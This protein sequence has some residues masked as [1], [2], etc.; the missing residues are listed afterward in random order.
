[1]WIVRIALQRPY[2]FIVMAVTILLATPYMLLTMP[3][4]ILPD[5][6]I[7]V[8]SVIWNYAGFSAQEM[9]NRITGPAERILTTTVNDIEHV[10]SNS[11]TGVAVIKIYFQPGASI[12]TAIAQ[13][14][15]SEQVMV[16]SL[17]VGTQPPLIITYSASA[18]PVTQLALSSATLPEQTVFDAAFNT[19]R[20]Q[21]VTIPGVAIPYPFGGKQRVISVDIDNA[22]LLSKGLSP[23]DV[24][25]AISA[26]NLILPSGTAKM[27]PTEF[28]VG[29]N[30]SPAPSTGSTIFP[31]AR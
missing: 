25:N 20:P 13:T 2:T 1:M 15:A 5:I 24:V 16:R 17:P 14:L 18:I 9:G 6:N 22:A 7:P 3:T 19:L 8:I 27:G 28:I 4:D 26:Q 31:C 12:G 30:G 23:V 10:E 29:M 21:L 11:Y